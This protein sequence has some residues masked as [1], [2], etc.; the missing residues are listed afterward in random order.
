MEKKRGNFPDGFRPRRRY[1][2]RPD[3]NLTRGRENQ[4]G[5]DRAEARPNVPGGM[6]IPTAERDQPNRRRAS[7]D[8]IRSDA[9]L[10]KKRR[11]TSRAK[12]PLVSLGPDQGRTAALASA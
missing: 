4:S 7:R 11:P 5:R 8:K 12:A 6:E 9:A 10:R 3:R 2:W 1:S